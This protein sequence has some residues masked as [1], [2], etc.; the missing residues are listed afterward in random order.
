MEEEISFC[1]GV[2]KLCKQYNVL[3]I[4]D[5]IRMGSCKKGTFLS[6]DW[7]GTEHKPDIMTMGKSI[8]GGVWP[9]S[10]VFGLDEVMNKMKPYQSVS[11]FSMS[12]MAVIAVTTA[13]GIYE[14]EKLQ[15]RSRGIHSKWVNLEVPV[16]AIL[17]SLR[18]R[19]EYLAEH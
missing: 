15:Q 13:L 2:R 10:C 8:S 6:S 9:T 4:A 5:E 16:V 18:G 12:S 14:E 19:L 7:M 3:F 17:S 11:I 1:V